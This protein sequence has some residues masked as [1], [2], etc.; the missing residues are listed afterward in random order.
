[1]KRTDLLK[2][3]SYVY[4][5]LPLIIFFLGWTKLYLVG[6][7]LTIALITSL[8][9]IV[10]KECN[11]DCKFHFTRADVIKIILIVALI[12]LWVYF[13]GIG[14]LT[15]Q[16]LDHKWRNEIFDVL[17][18]Y[19]W[20]VVSGTQYGTNGMSYYIGFWMLP[21]VIGKVFGLAA[22]YI[23]Q[24][25]WAVIGVLL[26][27]LLICRRIKKVAVCPLVVFIFFSGLDI[28]GLFIINH[29][30]FLDF[31]L[32]NHIESWV[33]GYQFSSF[34][35]QL[36]WVFNQ[37]IYGWIITLI[38]L[39]NTNNSIVLVMAAG[40][41]SASLP[42][43]GL[44]PIVLCSIW[45]NVRRIRKIKNISII[46]AIYTSLCTYENIIGLFSA[47]VIGT[48]LLSNNAISYTA[49]SGGQTKI[50]TILL[51]G[52]IA[53]LILIVVIE[54][55]RRNEV[56]RNNVKRVLVNNKRLIQI[57]LVLIG[58]AFVAYGA[59]HGL[60]A[61][62]RF[63]QENNIYKYILF[64]GL[65]V[66]IYIL[67]TYRKG[68]HDNIYIAS[69]VMFL[70]CPIFIL[71]SS[72]DFCMRACIPAQIVLFVYVV[73]T[74]D[75]IVI[76]KKKLATVIMILTLLIGSVTTISEFA[77]TISSYPEYEKN[78]IEKVRP[79]QILESMNFCS[80]V[81]ESIFYKHIARYY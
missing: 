4:I 54:I 7:P 6:I 35:T 17:V 43:V 59:N 31:T 28:V 70:L 73:K 80:H 71:G 76:Q 61:N 26:V 2:V 19:K 5:I 72:I 74:I 3:A 52:V 40:L 50:M 58:L 81:D 49:G 22:G 56:F 36:F 14:G 51:L 24:Y 12:A 30:E 38:A 64:L 66:G 46:N 48:L 11:S 39:E 8:Y 62:N 68:K 20:P 9:L 78:G 33:A 37:A 67:L 53:I 42:A 47:G 65:E 60:P 79:D 27:Y 69:I 29:K 25:V 41:F 13:S 57:L 32:G 10:K 63:T 45:N 77:R 1:M 21:A 34:T 75:D 15:W 18:E 44:M 16:N 23:A 55:I